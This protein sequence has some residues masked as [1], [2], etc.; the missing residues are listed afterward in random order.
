MSDYDIET[1]RRL[2]ELNII[3][4][5]LSKMAEGSLDSRQMEDWWKRL[6]E[7]QRYLNHGRFPRLRD[8]L[9]LYSVNS[10]PSSTC[11]KL[12]NKVQTT[13]DLLSFRDLENWR[14]YLLALSTVYFL[15]RSYLFY[16]QH[17]VLQKSTRPKVLQNVLTDTEFSARITHQLSETKFSF[18]Y[19]LWKLIMVFLLTTFDVLPK[20]WRNLDIFISKYADRSYVT[21]Y[22]IQFEHPVILPLFYLAC[23]LLWELLMAPVTYYNKCIQGTGPPK[24]SKQTI[25]EWISELGKN[26]FGYFW[27]IYLLIWFGEGNIHLNVHRRFHQIFNELQGNMVLSIAYTLIVRPLVPARFF[28]FAPLKAGK[29]KTA[30]E[31]LAKEL[32]FPL[33]NIYRSPSKHDSETDILIS[34]WSWK[35][36]VAIPEKV[37]EKCNTEDIVALVAA[38]IGNRKHNVLHELTVKYLVSETRLNKI[39]GTNKTSSGLWT[40]FNSNL[41]LPFQLEG[42]HKIVWI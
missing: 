21:S 36:N 32:K 26:Q 19:I 23:A 3:Q 15:A 22:E 14:T 6:Q 33:G 8:T 31:N 28:N 17:R 7:D 1:A 37:L 25:Q 38:K 2:L 30:I 34:G 24:H 39:M 11:M 18:C 27:K 9:N 5:L 42:D 40:L 4:S 29:T 20:I 35:R 41:D 13:R 10:H 16:R 12:T